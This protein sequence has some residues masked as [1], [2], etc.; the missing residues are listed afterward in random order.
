MKQKKKK[1]HFKDFF[2]FFHFLSDKKGFTLVE[3]T[4]VVAIF[5]VLFGTGAVALG[6]FISGQALH[7]AGNYLTQSLREARSFSV[8]Q[9]H[10]SEWGVYLD[11]ITEPDRLV[12]F[13]GNSYPLRDT[14]FD[15]IIPFHKSITFK[16]ISL[17]SGLHEIVFA[18]RTGQTGDY[19]VVTFGT[20][21][22]EDIQLSVN[23][24]GIIINDQ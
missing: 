2:K 15:Q 3:L 9:Y 22:D 7:T 6:N 8:A 12:L 4:F 14:D 21:A 23:A 18:K 16:Q 11:T 24:L 13:K 10:D 1:H 5:I 19:G 20:A 17:A